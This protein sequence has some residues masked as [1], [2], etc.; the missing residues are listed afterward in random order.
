M[1]QDQG[2]GGLLGVELELLGELHA[3]PLRLEQLDQLGPVLEVGAGAVAEREPGTA[4]AQVEVVL[5]PVR[6]L[7]ASSRAR[8]ASACASTPRATR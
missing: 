7:A 1:V 5:G 2:V 8:R 3:D 6:V 4:V